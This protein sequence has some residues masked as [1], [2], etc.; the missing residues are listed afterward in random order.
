MASYAGQNIEVPSLR[1]TVTANGAAIDDSLAV[2]FIRVTHEINKIS[3]AEV[4]LSGPVASDG[5]SISFSDADTFLPGNPIA[6]SAAYGDDAEVT[7]FTGVIVRH[8]LEMESDSVVNLK[9]HCKHAAVRMTF[10]RRE[11]EFGNKTDSAIIQAILGTYGLSATVTSTSFQNELFLQ[12]LATDW[13]VVLSRAEFNGM[14]IF[15]D[16]DSPAIKAPDFSGSPVLLVAPGGGLLSFQA[17]LNV[18][19]QAPSVQASAWDIKSLALQKASGSEPSVS[20]QGNVTPKQLS[21]KLSQTATLLNAGTPMSTD[22]LQAWAD[23]YL[24][25]MR[26]AA[27]KGSVTFVGS[28]LVKTGTIIQ[29]EGVGSKFNGN[30]YITGVTHELEDGVWKT[31]GKFGLDSKCINEQV[32]FSYLTA[33]GQIPAIQ[34]L[35]VATVKQLASD[36]QSLYRILITLPTNAETQNGV[37]ARYA[38]FYGTAGAG[39]GFLPEVGDE[40]LVG[41]IEND[42]RYPVILGSLYSSTKQSPNQATDENNYI[43]MLSTKTQLKIQFDDENKI[44]TIQTPGGNSITFSDQA[45]SIEITDQNSNSIKMTSSGIA[46][47]SA[48]DITIS[49]QGGVTISANMKLSLSAKQDLEASGLNVSCAAQMGFT[50]KGNATAELSASGQTTVKGGM[51]MIN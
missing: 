9:V 20:S 18:E 45:K 11:Q 28:S 23:N 44:I 25:R 22:E 24:L 13:D 43:K 15:L 41:F 32:D 2:S 21:A 33:T 50:A 39:L 29:L 46:L 47:S 16:G 36:P 34:G 10:G 30:A 27:L 40:V 49:A 26:L 6:I 35:Q 17:E 4:V 12:K 5:S 42:P 51:V 8:A 7:L 37:W 19:K 38:N 31:I 1:Y 3:S 14:L 48:K